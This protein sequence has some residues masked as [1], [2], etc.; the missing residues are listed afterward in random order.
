M[1]LFLWRLIKA[2]GDTNV[3]VILKIMS[4]AMKRSI[5]LTC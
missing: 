4:E 2:E 5:S 3:K 1:R